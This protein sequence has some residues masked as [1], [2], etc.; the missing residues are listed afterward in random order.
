MRWF[1]YLG[2]YIFLLVLIY[3]PAIED[4][5]IQ[6]FFCQEINCKDA[7]ITLL[8]TDDDAY[9]AF[10]DINEPDLLSYLQTTTHRIIV[11]ASTNDDPQRF[12]S[13]HRPGLMHH[14]Y[15]VVH[16][17]H[18]FTGSWNPTV[19]GTY[20]NDNYML[21]IHS[22]KL[23]KSFRKEYFFLQQK[24]S[25][26]PK[27]VVLNGTTVSLYFCPQHNCEQQVQHELQRTTTSI[28]LLSFTFTSKPLE[29][30]LLQA[31]QRGVL[32][33]AV[34]ESR[35][36]YLSTVE[37]SLSEAGATIRTDGNPRTMHGKVWILD[38][39]TLIL[40]SYNPTKAATTKNDETLLILRN[41]P[42]LIRLFQSEFTR[43]W[44]LSSPCC[45]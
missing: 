26:R 29:E 6:V 27:H 36:Q 38:N 3:V 17:A 7:L 20:Y 35:Q 32:V 42:D 41:N 31:V 11:D 22:K 2:V 19:Y 45:F 5:S 13:F 8:Q 43:I 28:E 24:H 18:V 1:L 9:C 14:K 30:E 39:H 33:R 16:D 12:L 4:G 21:L 44:G 10:Y 15:C 37:E 34:F 23:A 25:P 40:G